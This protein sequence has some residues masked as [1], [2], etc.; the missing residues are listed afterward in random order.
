MAYHV[1]WYQAYS[2]ANYP[3][4]QQ[5]VFAGHVHV[6]GNISAIDG[7]LAVETELWVVINALK[8]VK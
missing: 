2:E 3:K 7:F 1:A 8:Q 5:T 4:D 6:G